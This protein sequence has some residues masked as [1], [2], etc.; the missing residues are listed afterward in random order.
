MRIS[1]IIGVTTLVVEYEKN[2]AI[3]SGG[4]NGEPVINAYALHEFPGPTSLALWGLG[5]LFDASPPRAATKCTTADWPIAGTAGRSK[6]G[7]S[8]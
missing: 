6:G 2:N 1:N 3:V 5:G 8:Y 7:R 4:F